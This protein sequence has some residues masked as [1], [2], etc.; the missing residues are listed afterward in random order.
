[1]LSEKASKEEK[2][3]ML[4]NGESGFSY[5]PGHSAKCFCKK[6]KESIIMDT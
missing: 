3:E 5:Y 2:I 6:K 4:N 1:M